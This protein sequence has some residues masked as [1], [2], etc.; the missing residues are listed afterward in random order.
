MRILVQTD[1]VFLELESGNCLLLSGVTYDP[2][3]QQLDLS[4]LE[5]VHAVD[6]IVVVGAKELLVENGVA[7][8]V[9]ADDQV[10]DAEKIGV[11]A[12]EVGAAKEIEATKEQIEEVTEKPKDPPP[13][14]DEPIGVGEVVAEVRR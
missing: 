11:Y 2:K 12:R 10:I 13:K 6:G 7:K 8:I 14:E 4:S 5:I 1:G 3:S 9:L